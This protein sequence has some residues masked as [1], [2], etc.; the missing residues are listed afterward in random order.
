M[1]AKAPILALIL[2]NFALYPGVFSASGA[3]SLIDLSA[4]STLAASQ[5]FSGPGRNLTGDPKSLRELLSLGDN[6][7]WRGRIDPIY[8]RSFIA[9]SI[10]VNKCD[11]SQQ[12]TSTVGTYPYEEYMIDPTGYSNQPV[13]KLGYPKVKLCHL[14]LLFVFVQL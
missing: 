5:P 4:R 12:C 1:R 11:G 9:P 14:K 8:G 3:E 2:A 13:L 6:P 7:S 10:A